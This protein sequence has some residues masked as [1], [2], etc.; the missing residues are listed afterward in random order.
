M[1][2]LCKFCILL[3]FLF[4]YAVSF[5]SNSTFINNYVVAPNYSEVGNYSEVP[6]SSEVGNS[7]EVPNSIEAPISS[8]VANVTKMANST[9]VSNYTIEEVNSSIE[10][11]NFKEF[12]PLLNQNDDTVYVINFWATWCGPCIKEIPYFEQLGNKYRDKNLKVIMISMDMPDL[13][14]SKLIP[15]IEKNNMKNDVI[16]L[17]DPDFN[18]WIP[19]VNKEWTGAIPAT[20]IYSK[21][22]REFYAK[23]L[24]FSELEEIVKPL[25][26]N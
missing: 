18:S 6:N 15:F 24:T 12:E 10:V 26:S 21:D 25:L 14:D 19:I 16:L 1:K 23:E 3:S 17:D 7:G 4:V 2:T 5:A 22:F 9:E 13:I 11:L 8:V 20:L